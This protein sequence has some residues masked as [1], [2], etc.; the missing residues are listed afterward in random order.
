MKKYEKDF[1][2]DYSIKDIEIN[3]VIKELKEKKYEILEQV[4]LNNSLYLVIE[5]Y[6]LALGCKLATTVIIY[7]QDGMMKV[8]II[9]AGGKLSEFLDLGS[10]SKIHTDV[11]S[12]VEEIFAA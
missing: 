12:I 7:E 5:K 11:I 4:E 9:T 10:Y 6:T 3:R 8:R 2:A 1:I